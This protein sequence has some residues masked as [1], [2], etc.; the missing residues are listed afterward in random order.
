MEWIPFTQVDGQ[1]ITG[2]ISHDIH[3]EIFKRLNVDVVFK[4]ISWGRCMAGVETGTFAT[5]SDASAREN[6]VNGPMPISFYPVALYTRPDM[7]KKSFTFE[8]LA[9]VTVGALQGY[10]V[11]DDVKAKAKWKVDSASDEETALKKLQAKLY[12]YYIDDTIGTEPL[13]KRIGF[14]VT[15]LEPL[16]YSDKLYLV[17]GK[18]YEKLAADYCAEFA[19]LKQEGFVNQVYKAALGKTYEEM[20]Q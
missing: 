4:H 7:Q 6:L 20:A 13:A 17:F 5:V 2:G 10:A 14:E 16:Q 15:W 1:N 3:K 19:K 8:E 11:T 9:S 12:D 18:K